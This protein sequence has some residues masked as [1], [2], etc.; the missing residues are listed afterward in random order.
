[1]NDVKAPAL[2]TLKA[3][4]MTIYRSLYRSN[5]RIDILFLLKKNPG[6]VIISDIARSIDRS[7]A[8]TWGAIVGDGKKYNKMYSLVSLG[9]ISRLEGEQHAFFLTSKGWEV[10]RIL[11]G[12]DR[13]RNVR[14]DQE[15]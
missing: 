7:Y 8:N 5:T 4:D 14:L 15:V 10:V 11:E 2:E 13:D 1:M 3:Y 12:N 6:G 9:L